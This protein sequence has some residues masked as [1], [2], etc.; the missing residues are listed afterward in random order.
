MAEK[1]D[2]TST[3]KPI[4]GDRFK[5]S[6]HKEIQCFTRCCQDLRLILTPYDI[7]RLK[8]RMEISSE[9]FL[10]NHTDTSFDTHPIFPMIILKMLQDKDKRC[11]FVTSDGCTVYEDRPSACRIYP[12]GRASTQPFGPEATLE[13]FFI[14]EED[15]CLGFQ[16]SREWSI[17]EWL[18]NE[19]INEYNS[20]NDKWSEIITSSKG[21]GPEGDVQKKTQM[22]YMASYNL[23]RFREFLFKSPFFDRFEV[24]PELKEKLATDDISLMKFAFVWLRFSLFGEQTIQ[25]K[26]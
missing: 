14:V 18:S 20:M 23:D 13:K 3:F 6:C 5:F 19:G 24:D 15:H 8:N 26:S 25:I 9:N 22:F 7:L 16:E 17:K 2:G 1:K 12:L 10:D 11:P 21:L 4:T